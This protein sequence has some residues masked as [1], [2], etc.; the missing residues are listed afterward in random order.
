MYHEGRELLADQLGVDPSAQ[1]EQVYLRHLAG[2]RSQ[3][4]DAERAQV[5]ARYW[6]SPAGRA[7]RR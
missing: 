2:R 1:L 3:G 7:Q 6:P 5:S 4:T